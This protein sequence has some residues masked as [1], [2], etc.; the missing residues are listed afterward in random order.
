MT[1]R[2]SDPELLTTLHALRLQ[3]YAPTH[4]VAARFAL[5]HDATAELLLDFQAHG[6]VSFSEFAGTGGWSLTATGRQ[7]NERLLAAELDDHGLRDDV[8]EVHAA[9]LPLNARF[10]DAVTRWQIRPLPG[11]P[12]TSNDH[13][14][15]RWDDRVIDALTGLGRRLTPLTDRLAND[16]ARFSGYGTRYTNA[17]QRVNRGERRWVD[18]IDVD[19]CH[20]VWFELHEDLI[21]TLGLQRGTEPPTQ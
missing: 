11:D 19:S 17:A 10:Q 7:E 4:Q 12:M 5:D 18:G 16:L 6:W 13:T 2:Q 3:G 8:T 9:F 1:P 21:A 14:D 15:H 20:R